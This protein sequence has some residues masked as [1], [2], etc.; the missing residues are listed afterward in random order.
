MA[1]SARGVSFMKSS[2]VIASNMAACV[3][4]YP[5]GDAAGV[6]TGAVKVAVLK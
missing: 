2:S 1:A 4:G 3:W 5:G 6:I